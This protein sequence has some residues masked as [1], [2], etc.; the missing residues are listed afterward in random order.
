MRMY[1]VSVGKDLE[2]HTKN[3]VDSLYF[4]LAWIGQKK[5]HRYDKSWTFNGCGPNKKQRITLTQDRNVGYYSNES[6][7]EMVE[8]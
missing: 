3:E 6:H 8:M 5:R 1:R 2:G 7:D 4:N